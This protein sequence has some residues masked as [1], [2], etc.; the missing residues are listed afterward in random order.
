MT[1]A[2]TSATILSGVLNDWEYELPPGTL[3]LPA[4]DEDPLWITS[5]VHVPR[6]KLRKV[7]VKPFV[8]EIEGTEMKGAADE[9]GLAVAPGLG[10]AVGDGDADGDGVTSGAGSRT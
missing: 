4:V 8:L 1:Y 5:T 7:T 3:A 2:S 10:E 6:R 9:V